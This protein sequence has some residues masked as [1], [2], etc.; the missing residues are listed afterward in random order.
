MGFFSL[1]DALFAIFTTFLFAIP[2]LIAVIALLIWQHK[3]N[4]GTAQKAETIKMAHKYCRNCGKVLLGNSNI[5]SNCGV[6]IGTGK[7]YCYRCGQRTDELAVV[8]VSCGVQL[9]DANADLEARKS[10][11]AAGFLGIIFGF[12]G[13]H[14]FYLGY[15]IKA[16]AQL[17]ITIFC[18]LFTV[19]FG[20]TITFIWGLVEGIMIF[21]GGISKD[22]TG[23]PLR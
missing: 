21:A 23:A 2:V 7:R 3:K 14:N 15:T 9:N 18:I 4:K 12:I 8:C 6:K 10:K 16:F 19:P 17:L 22:A 5:C 13:V 20:I 1:F 11:V